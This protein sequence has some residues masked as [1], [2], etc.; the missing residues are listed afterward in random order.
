MPGADGPPAAIEI[1]APAKVNLYLHITGR[2]ADGF[3]ELDSLFVRADIGD[4]LRLCAAA[5]LALT[6]D[7]PFAPALASTGAGANLVLSAA[8]RL[9]SHLGREPGAAIHLEKNLPVAA[10]LGGGSADAA[11]ALRGLAALWQ[12]DVPD[13]ELRLLAAGLG[14]DV[15]ACLT[16]HPLQVSGIGEQLRPAPELPPAWLVLANPGLA[17]GTA[18]VFARRAGG[19][20]RAMP[21]DRPPADAAT[22]AGALLARRNDLET[23]A[24]ALVP[25][26]ADVL[27]ALAGEAGIL[28]ARMS[29]SGATCF[30][31]AAT[32]ADAEA[33][34]SRIGAAHPA[35]WVVAA[36]MLAS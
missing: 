26:I 1:D 5:G 6:V 30:G 18:D 23:A 12:A 3:H 21:L 27:A 24:I 7:G 31:L 17:L 13:N 15:P 11:A 22:L 35:W 16:R 4:R 32:A 29:G 33:A 9:A 14:A 25:Q 2:R 34:A 10:G 8:R 20:S 28:L 36:P 19:F